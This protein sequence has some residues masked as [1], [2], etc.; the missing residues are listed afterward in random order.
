MTDAETIQR[1]VE[2]LLAR[3]L[4]D[5]H[6][7]LGAHPDG[8]DVVVRAWRPGAVHVTVHPAQGEPVELR[9]THD[10]GVFEGRIAD[11]TLPLRYGLS[12]DYGETGT[13]PVND[14]YRHTPTVG[15]LD[16]HLFGEGRHEAL[17]ERLGAHVGERDGDVG[18]AFA[19]WAPNARSVSVV[20]DFNSWDGRLHPMRSLGSSGVWELFVPDV[21][22]GAVY[23]FEIRTQSGELVL[24]ADPFAFAAQVPP[25]TDSIVHRST[26]E[27]RDADWLA[28]RASED[29]LKAPMSVYEVHLGSWR[30]RPEEDD[31]LLDY[32]ELADEL[33][34][35]VKDMGFTHV[36]LLPVMA[37]PFPG[38]WGYQVTSYFAPTPRH[39]SPD[40]F[41]EF[42]DR[43]HEHGIGVLLD[44]VPAHFPRDAW[45][46]AQFDGTA[47]YEHAD[48]RR[49][50][51]PDWGTLIFNFGRNEVKNFLLASALFWARE[52]HVD[53]LRVDAVASML[54]LDYSRQEGEWVPNEHGGREDLEAVAF[55]K[56]MNE[57]VYGR[58]AGV[59]TAAE[60]STSWPGVSRPTYLGGLGF[61]FKWNM[62]WMHDTLE[63]FQQDPVY[64]RY[65]HH[66][67]TFSLHYAFSENFILP[68]SHDEVVHGKKSLL[69]KMPGDRWQQ[70]AN[71][72]ALYAYMW[73]HPG[74]K[75]L[76]MGQEFGQEREWSHER[77]LDW[78]LLE[79]HGHQGVQAAVRDLNRVYL[80]HPAL[81][82][83]DAEPT[84]FWWLEPNDAER[85]IV[86]FARGSAF[87]PED[88]RTLESRDLL[89]CVAN[90][91]PVPREGYRVGLPVRGPWREALNTDAHAYGGSGVGNGGRVEPDETPWH[92]QPCSAEITLPPLGV[93]WLVPDA[94]DA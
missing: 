92:G 28:R 72:R 76:F 73:A 56:E 75:L 63:Y 91:S 50:A 78:H 46:L 57:V 6:R 47:L 89:V 12:V 59:L 84:G 74:K 60:E 19:V 25:Q 67:L 71:L 94:P 65:H 34:A 37:H 33:A 27:W 81:W 41:R 93:L 54:Y 11:A 32:R 4:A 24:H 42:V 17:Y 55:L 69:E 16:L 90:L 31:R 2:A 22:D 20:G 86:A 62:G 1:D 23:K 9:R 51:H 38:S 13:F 29:H 79:D 82:E 21:G 8:D 7:L 83:V 15:E 35:Y 18:T 80:E 70:L 10:A 68:L 3:D 43:M 45:A 85:N 39:G 44:W 61:G 66:G 48:P 87:D 5:P 64:R 14:P 53:G 30:R 36:E 77:S 58:E 40:D 49:G 88:P 26:H 52:F